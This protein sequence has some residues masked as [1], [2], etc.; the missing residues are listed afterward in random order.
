MT[1]VSQPTEPAATITDFQSLGIGDDLLQGLDSMNIRVPTPIQQQAIPKVLDGRDLIAC[2]QTG[3][4][5][6]AAFLLPLIDV[7]T[8]YRPKVDGSIRALI[9]V[10]TRELALQIDQQMQAIAYFTPITSIPLYGGSDGNTFDAQKQALTS[11]VEVVIATPGKLLSHLN[12][13]YV[14]LNGLEFLIL[15]EADRMM[16]MG[17]VDDIRKII[18]FLPKERQSLMFSATMPSAIRELTKQILHDPFEISIALSKPAAGVDQ[19][20]Y[21]IFDMQKGN[22]LE[23]ILNTNEASSIVIF[24]GRKIEVKNLARHLQKRGFNAAGMHSDLEQTERESV[25]LDFRNRKLRVLVATDVVS[26]GIDIDDIDLVIN[27]DVPRDPEDYVHRVGRTARAAKKGAAVTFVNEKQMREFGRIEELIGYEVK[28]MDLPQGIP[29]GPR[30]DP[31]AR[32]AGGKQN[33]HRRSGG[34]GRSGGG[35]R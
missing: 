10:P 2:A 1:D 35:Q 24:A 3:T 32:V 27:Y 29:A 4:G 19:Q 28:K 26:R 11:G 34:R 23:H 21:V 33:G 20:A 9:I 30:Y 6:T 15:D 5:K 14:P 18:T 25:M 17:F 13:G 31:K 22:I 8:S 16:D 12:L 7:I